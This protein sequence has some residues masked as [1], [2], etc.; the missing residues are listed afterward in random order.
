MFGRW[1]TLIRALVG[2]QQI[3]ED[4]VPFGMISSAVTEAEHKAGF[5]KSFF[6]PSERSQGEGERSFERIGRARAERVDFVGVEGA[7]QQ[8]VAY[9]NFMDEGKVNEGSFDRL[10]ELMMPVLIA[11]GEFKRFYPLGMC[12]WGADEVIF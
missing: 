3:G 5:L 9:A 4:L 7:G 11:N 2:S 8:G 10:E 1:L 12:G 6:G